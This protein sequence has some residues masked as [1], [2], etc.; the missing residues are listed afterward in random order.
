MR[1]YVDLLELVCESSPLPTGE[2][3]QDISI[4]FARLG[5]CYMFM[6]SGKLKIPPLASPLDRL[7]VIVFDIF[8]CW[9]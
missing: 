5:G 9:R 4:I 1:Q 3:L 2:V 6:Y 7:K 8:C